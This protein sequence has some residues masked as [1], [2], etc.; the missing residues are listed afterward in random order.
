[1]IFGAR[2][3]D[4]TLEDFDGLLMHSSFDGKVSGLAP[5]I[6][7]AFENCLYIFVSSISIAIWALLLYC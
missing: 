1:M 4:Q 7:W 5:G 3:R 2:E 6:G